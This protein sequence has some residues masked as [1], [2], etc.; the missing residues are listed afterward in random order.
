MI[1]DFDNVF[2]IIV[3]L[4]DKVFPQKMGFW[5]YIGVFTDPFFYI[6]YLA[7]LIFPIAILIY[8]FV[9]GILQAILYVVGPIAFAFS[10]IPFFKDVWQKWLGA[11]VTVCFWN[12]TFAII[13]LF[14]ETMYE[15]V[16]EFYAAQTGPFQY[17]GSLALLLINLGMILLLIF[18][19]KITSA[20][21]QIGG[22][23]I[24]S[25]GSQMQGIMTAAV[26]LAQYHKLAKAM[27]SVKR[28]AGVAGKGEGGANSLTPSMS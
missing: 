18:T 1:Y 15:Q 25:V 16:G 23:E 4:S 13:M 28:A 5:D 27:K 3:T 9:Q 11:Y 2:N 20:Y 8:Q 17:L 12:V 7:A 21:L 19:P 22:K 14:A 26:S 24:S 6:G 10:I